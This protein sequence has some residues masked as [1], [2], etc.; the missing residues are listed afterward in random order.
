MERIK[1]FDKMIALANTELDIV[2][3]ITP[4]NLNDENKRF[5]DMYAIGKRYDPQY[6]YEIRNEFT[7]LVVKIYSYEFGT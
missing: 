7:G 5:L 6:R 3:S 2:K 4:I 1:N